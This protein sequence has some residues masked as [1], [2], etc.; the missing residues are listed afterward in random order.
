[1][2]IKIPSKNIYEIS[3]PKIRD[4]VID[5]VSVEQTV[6]TPNNDYETPIYNE[7]IEIS[8]SNLETNSNTDEDTVIISNTTTG[9]GYAVR[10]ATMAFVAYDEKKS[11]SATLYI[12]AV[13]GN[14][15][16][17]K[18]LLGKDKDGKANIKYSIYGKRINYTAKT[19]ATLEWGATTAT[20]KVSL[21]AISHTELSTSP[22]QSIDFPEKIEMMTKDNPPLGNKLAQ[23][24][25]T[26]IG[27]LKN[28]VNAP[29][30]TIDGVE[31]YK[32]SFSIMSSIRTIQLNGSAY[33]QEAF[34]TLPL[35]GVSTQYI[36]T[37]IEITIYGNTIGINLTDGS[38][39]YGSGNKPHSLS[40]NE[41]LQ[42]SATSLVSNK[43]KITSATPIIIGM[44][45]YEFSAEKPINSSVI[46]I[47]NKKHTV[48]PNENGYYISSASI[49]VENQEYE[50]FEIIN[51]TDKLANDILQQ[52]ANGKETA[53]L[54]C[55]I[56]DYYD[57][58]GTKAI[59]SK[60]GK[61]TFYLHDKV[62][63]MV[64]GTDKKDHP[65]SKYKDGTPKVFEVIGSKVFY[66]GAVW[67]ELTLLEK[68]QQN[69]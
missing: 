26:D 56:S 16:I 43:I 55:D 19:N 63:P 68:S 18:L 33:S 50:I 24:E 22:E 45:I 59:D 21:S 8:I 35:E 11:Y 29:I 36:P 1:M 32:L 44:W 41:L 6:V 25:L 12:Q 3:N 69:A 46:F 65:M 10:M 28:I 15:Y 7:K 67:Q 42:D 9:G 2:A 66:D 52:Y 17:N 39:T 48:H 38:V 49:F 64:Y 13:K 61:M 20:A 47:D 60:G 34:T 4:N 30:E 27:T 57:E 5:N 51:C 58:S 40:G 31:Y 62:I 23:V 14:K 54:L 53:T 37:Q